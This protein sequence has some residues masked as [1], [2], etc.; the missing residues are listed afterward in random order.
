MLLLLISS[1][2]VKVRLYKSIYYSVCLEFDFE[3]KIGLVLLTDILQS[4]VHVPHFTTPIVDYMWVVTFK[5][6]DG[7]YSVE[8]DFGPVQKR[9]FVQT[10]E[11]EQRWV[12]FA[13]SLLF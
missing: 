5:Y 2:W 4:R 12:L 11:Q 7:N 9:K 13:L 6:C 3:L 8:D 10:L 1:S